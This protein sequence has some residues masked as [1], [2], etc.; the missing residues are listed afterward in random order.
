MSCS[1]CQHFCATA[2]LCHRQHAGVSH[3]ALTPEHHS[4]SLS[5]VWTT[6]IRLRAACLIH[7][8]HHNHCDCTRQGY[9]RTNSSTVQGDS[10]VELRARTGVVQFIRLAF[11]DNQETRSNK[12]PTILSTR[13]YV[14][15]NAPAPSVHYKIDSRFWVLSSEAGLSTM[16]KTAKTESSGCGKTAAK[17][18]LC[19]VVLL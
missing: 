8:R 6:G 7:R 4:T 2:S 1:F 14:P 13:I 5:R 9:Q 11:V 18:R 16:R 17:K 19:E 15:Q 10:P 12:I 3:A